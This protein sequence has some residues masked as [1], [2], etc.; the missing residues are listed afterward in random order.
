MIYLLMIILATLI[1]SML[2][3]ICGIGGGVV[4]KPV[5]DSLGIM[6]VNTVSF[7]SGCTVLCMT[8]YSVATNLKS[9]SI[10][11]RLNIAVPVSIGAAIGGI[12]GK[13]IFQILKDSF[14][15]TEFIGVIQAGC[16]FFLTLGTILY[17][18]KKEKIDTRR[19]ENFGI[20][21][22]IGLILGMFSSFLGIGG[23]PFNLVVL[24]FF[25]SLGTKEA[26]QTSLFIILFSQIT[27]LGSTIIAGKLPEFN[28]YILVGMACMGILGAVLGRMLN[29]T[30]SPQ[31]VD[32][33]FIRMAIVIMCI[34]AYNMYR[35][36]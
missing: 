22:L 33:L 35:I 36:K 18:L 9:K 26:A 10:P 11:I 14:E 19:I 20:C 12:V 34:C 2:G 25:F 1:A 31:M 8:M 13:D 23:G 15:N 16:L 6:S 21:I 32:K 28:L 4:I 29:K 27:S 7:L 24:S 3:A 30:L 5:L 17:T